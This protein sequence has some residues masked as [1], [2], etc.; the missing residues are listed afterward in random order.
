[1]RTIGVLPTRSARLSGTARAGG[2]TLTASR[3][4]R[5]PRVWTCVPAPLGSRHGRRFPG[6]PV[7][8]RVVAVVLLAAVAAAGGW[9]L[10]GHRS[11]EERYR[12][13]V[14]EVCDRSDQAIAAVRE[15]GGTRPTSSRRRL[16][17]TETREI[18][19]PASP[20]PAVRPGGRLQ[21]HGDKL[22]LPDRR[23]QA[24][25]A[26]GQSRPA[27]PAHPPRHA[28]LAQA[29]QGPRLGRTGIRTTQERVV[30]YCRCACEVSS[31]SSFTPMSPSSPSSPAPAHERELFHCGV[32]RASSTRT[33]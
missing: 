5:A 32:V 17:T 33:R 18:R 31:V 6:V 25:L 28:A 19:T 15:A 10:V 11:P 27:P 4:T 20:P 30:S 21:A 24:R 22:A 23:V 7:Q 13:Q 1:M 26:L 9:M 12:E 29:L 14:A 3:V 8:I 16:Q 2:E